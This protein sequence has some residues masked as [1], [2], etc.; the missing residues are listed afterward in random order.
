MHLE[1]V[2]VST[3]A[4]SSQGISAAAISAVKQTYRLQGG[5]TQTIRHCNS[6]DLLAR[7][8]QTPHPVNRHCAGAQLAHLQVSECCSTQ[9]QNEP[10]LWH[11]C[12]TARIWQQLSVQYISNRQHAPQHNLSGPLASTQVTSSLQLHCHT[13]AMTGRSQ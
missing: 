11:M 13:H 4:Q 7:P 6:A 10:M 3:R 1:A 5:E 2:K 9:L 8:W 12:C